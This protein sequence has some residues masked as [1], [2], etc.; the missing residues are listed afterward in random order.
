MEK[1]L[2]SS[3]LLKTK[4]QFASH[5]GPTPMSVLVKD[6]MMY[7]VVGKS[8]VNLGMGRVALA[9][10]FSTCPFTVSTLI[11]AAFLSGGPCDAVG[12]MYR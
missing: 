8:A 5:I 3:F 11:V 12:A 9:E 4:V 1:V 10:D 2:C 6:G 7:P